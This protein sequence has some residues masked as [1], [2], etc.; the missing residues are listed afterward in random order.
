MPFGPL[1]LADGRVQYRLWAP[2]AARVDLVCNGATA[3]MAAPGPQHEVQRQDQDADSAASTPD[4]GWFVSAPMSHAPGMRYAFRID[5]QL[6]VPDPASRHNPDGVHA[7]SALTAPGTF[8]WPEPGWRGRPWHEAVVYELHIG[9]FTPEGSFAAAIARLDDLVALGITAIELLP[10]ASFGGQR[11]WGY[12]G[13]LLYAPHAAY[14]TPDDFKR[15]VAA[16]HARGLMVLLDVVYNHFGP[17]GN[18]LNAYA[19]AF[20]KPELHTPWGAAINFD[21][22]GSATVRRFFIDN[23]LYWLE[24]FQLDGLRIDAVH[25]MH[26]QSVPHFIDALASAVQQ[27]PGRARPV[28]L[29][30]E[31]DHNDATR[32]V[33]NGAGRPML[34]TAQW[35]DDLHHAAHVL[36]TGETDGY[37]ADYAVKPAALLGRALAEGFV[38]QGQHSEYRGQAHGTPSTSL[39]PLAFVN[40]LQNHDQ[41]GNRALGERLAALV[42]APEAAGERSA[43]LRALVACQLLSPAVPMLFMGEEYAASTPF[44]YFCDFEGDLARAVTEGRRNEFSRFARFADPNQRSRIPDPNALATFQASQLDWAERDLAPHAHWLAFYRR[45]LGIR[46]RQLAPWLAQAGSGSWQLDGPGLL[47]LRWPLGN[48]TLH[49]RANLHSSPAPAAPALPGQL[50]YS[51]VEPAAEPGQA[52]QAADSTPH[53]APA[54]LSAWAVQVTLHQSA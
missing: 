27:G 45:L 50:L 32:L 49:L 42:S 18:Y 48:A 1:W 38:Y 6:T 39:P 46:Q 33:R 44:L 41:I 13:V 17:D 2:G 31:N 35:N 7:A 30:L 43:A 47:T 37:Y 28:H 29:V 23:A 5:G 24:E 36:L 9:C 3:P 14:G 15:L 20:F 19:P 21:S 40:A 51:S 8:N 11:G 52:G 26:D 16:A 10:V 53:R 25:A 4:T 34:A 54:A 22:P 12:D